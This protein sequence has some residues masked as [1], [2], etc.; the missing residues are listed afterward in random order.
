MQLSIR[1]MTVS[2]GTLAAISLTPPALAGTDVYAP[3]WEH[4]NPNCFQNLRN[5]GQFYHSNDSVL[6]IDNCADGWGAQSETNIIVTDNTKLCYNGKG[7]GTSASC[8]YNF[9]EGRIGKIRGRS[10]DNGVLKGDGEWH[11][12]LT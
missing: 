2:V 7:S 12:F 1:T 11:A 6:A 3:H 9:V 8:D 10:I 5:G 4:G